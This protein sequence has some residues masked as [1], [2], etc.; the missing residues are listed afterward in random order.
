MSPS[1]RTITFAEFALDFMN[2]NNIPFTAYWAIHWSNVMYSSEGV[3]FKDGE[4]FEDW[5][6]ID[7]VMA[8]VGVIG[9]IHGYTIA[10][11]HPTLQRYTFVTHAA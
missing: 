8:D 5:G 11:Q 2:S 7:S 9:N 10:T 1:T 6:E 3:W 4:E